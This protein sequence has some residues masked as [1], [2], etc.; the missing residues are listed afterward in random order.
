M[1]WP[2]LAA[3]TTS[4][5]GDLTTPRGWLPLAV[6]GHAAGAADNRWSAPTVVEASCGIHADSQGTDRLLPPAVPAAPVGLRREPCASA[7]RGGRPW[8][9]GFRRRSGASNAGCLGIPIAALGAVAMVV[10]ALVR[11]ALAKRRRARDEPS[12]ARPSPT[13]HS[14]ASQPPQQSRQVPSRARFLG[15]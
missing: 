15:R 9:F 8:C 2:S 12:E 3:T 13:P 1:R 5:V 11:Y 6:A 7:G 10:T 4:S 14:G